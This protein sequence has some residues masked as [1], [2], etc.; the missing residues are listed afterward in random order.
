MYLKGGLTVWHDSCQGEDDYAA[1]LFNNWAFAQ[2]QGDCRYVQLWTCTDCAIAYKR[3][4]CGTLFPRC[5][6]GDPDA[7]VHMCRDTCFV[8]ASCF[9][10]QDC[11]VS[12]Y[13]LRSGAQGERG[14]G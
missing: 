13:V 4:L 6:D 1:C 12:H 5:A 3:W 9:Q 10:D 8:R 11:V 14:T 2:R 7:R